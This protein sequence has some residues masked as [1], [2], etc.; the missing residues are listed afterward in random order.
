MGFNLLNGTPIINEQ[1]IFAIEYLTEIK[2]RFTYIDWS[3][4][5]TSG[6]IGEEE[7]TAYQNCSAK[8]DA[9]LKGVNYE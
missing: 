6:D 5:Y 9:L 8:L 4:G 3:G 1:F 2:N 7:K